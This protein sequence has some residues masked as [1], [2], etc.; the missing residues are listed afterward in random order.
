MESKTR[1]Q[2][3]TSYNTLYCHP[4]CLNLHTIILPIFFIITTTTACSLRSRSSLSLCRTT[5]SST[6]VC[7]SFN[8]SLVYIFFFCLI[9]FSAHTSFYNTNLYSIF[10]CSYSSR[11]STTSSRFRSQAYSFFFAAFVPAQVNHFTPVGAFTIVFFSIKTR[12][13]QPSS[14]RYKLCRSFQ[15]RK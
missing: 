15:T 4:T 7:P 14:L 12:S 5:S 3:V 6:G 13:I 2:H 10:L 9:L 1:P 8:S 11:G